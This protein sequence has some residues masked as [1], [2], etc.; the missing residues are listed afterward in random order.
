MKALHVM[1]TLLL[2]KQRKI[3]K[4][5]DHLKSLETTF[6]IWKEG[7]IIELEE[8]G[9]AIQDRLKSDGNPNDIV[10]TSKKFKLQTQK[11]KY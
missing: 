10:E 2:Q 9:K 8:E 4:S 3:S 11:R 5:M 6:E 1:P 7:S